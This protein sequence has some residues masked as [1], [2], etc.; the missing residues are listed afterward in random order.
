M[1]LLDKIPIKTQVFL[2]GLLILCIAGGATLFVILST[3]FIQKSL[4]HLTTQSTPFQV[5]TIQAQAVLQEATTIIIKMTAA[6]SPKEIEDKKEQMEKVIAEL[7]KISSELTVLS[8]GNNKIEK[9]ANEFHDTSKTVFAI[10]IQKINAEIAAKESSKKMSL[11]LTEITNKLQEIDAKIKNIQK[12]VSEKLSSATS[13]ATKASERMR[14][15]YEISTILRSVEVAFD[16]VKRSDNKRALDLAKGKFNLAISKALTSDFFKVKDTDKEIKKLYDNLK[17]LQ[18]T[19]VAK[20][21][22]VDIFDRYLSKE[23]PETRK[24]KDASEKDIAKRIFNIVTEISSYI[25]YQ[26]E[27]IGSSNTELKKSVDVSKLSSDV[28]LLSSE[29]I[30]IGHSIE[31]GAT[32]L[33]QAQNIQEL[34]TQT[35]FLSVRF[36]KVD[37]TIKKLSDIFNVLERK[38][39]ISFL[40]KI[41][42]FFK[43]IKETLIGG[44][45]LS[46]KIERLL[47]AQQKALTLSQ[48][49]EQMVIEQQQK[50]RETLKIASGE[51]EKAVIAVN[52]LVK[53]ITIA[54]IIL[55]SIGILTGI[56]AGIIG[57]KT[58]TSSMFQITRVADSIAQGNLSLDLEI[59]GTPDIRSM[60]KSLLKKFV[61]G[62]QNV[63]KGVV[64]ASREVTSASKGMRNSSEVMHN[65]AQAQLEAVEEMASSI[66]E[67][68]ASIKAIAEDTKETLSSA[69]DASASSIEMSSAITE[70]AESADRLASSMDAT[71]TSINEITVSLKEVASHVDTL[72]RVSEEVVSAAMEINSTIKEVSMLSGDQATL[73]K[74]VKEEAISVGMEA[75]NNTRDGMEKI[76]EEVSATA[77]AIDKLGEK[78][79]EIGKIISTIDEIADTTNL[80]AL[81]AAILAAQ[82]GEHGKGFAVVA[83]EVKNLAERT[84]SSTKEIA[85]LIGQVQE[86]IKDTVSSI[87]RSLTRVE[88]GARLSRDAGEALTKITESTEASLQMALKIEGA[89]EEQAKG[90][91]QV[92]EGIQNIS[93]MIEEI[94]KAT[95]EQ[96]RAS[97]MISQ[98]TEEVK[99]ISQNVKRSIAEQ[100]KEGKHI[101]N[102]ITDVAQK[103]QAIANATT[104]QRKAS[105]RIV[106]AVETMKKEAENNVALAK[107]LDKMVAYLDSQGAL[108]KEKVESFKA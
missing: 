80:L 29:L 102:V 103:M 84:A 17:N 73:A 54:T 49:I 61:D 60:G 53:R 107:E 57:T 98:A 96:K 63:L 100:S 92:V 8:L 58:I 86:G 4:S 38:E 26:F 89:T 52:Q 43:E 104:E 9:L 46:K 82:A 105:E 10:A 12:A 36:A 25:D 62:M 32:K 6:T 47:Q 41:T 33:L 83:A 99:D 14:D 11:K 20:D 21:G 101:S 77:R 39:D 94:K 16:D 65:S 70:M 35:N 108:L 59:K 68:G 27:E 67:M 90:V 88:D 15:L 19:V 50:S 72:S 91:G 76:K 18:A 75:V 24:V 64:L 30:A 37:S 40:Q 44:D 79:T 71:A 28:L 51:Q 97:E 56:T 2:N 106:K 55:G 7:K 5:K 23:D 95:D 34:S 78:S 22:F 48:Q 1:S 87:G 74:K 69:E 85:E 45:G 13:T 31:V 81:N 66:E 42:L 3:T 93:D